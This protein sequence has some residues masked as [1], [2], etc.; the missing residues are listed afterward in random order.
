MTAADVGLLDRPTILIEVI[1]AIKDLRCA[2]VGRPGEAVSPLPTMAFHGV[3][4]G[5]GK[6]E[7][8]NDWIVCRICSEVAFTW[9][10]RIGA[11]HDSWPSGR[12]GYRVCDRVVGGHV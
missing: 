5:T 3:D 7:I 11:A 10:A 4:W 12:I 6:I 8:C 2:K 9:R 1:A